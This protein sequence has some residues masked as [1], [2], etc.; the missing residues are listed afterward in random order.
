MDDTTKAKF[1]E[2]ARLKN[3]AAAIKER[4][5]LLEPELLDTMLGIDGVNTKIE[6]P[7]GAF[8]IRKTKTWTLP[9]GLV[10]AQESL[11]I[12]IATAKKEGDATFEE[13]PGLS[14]R[15]K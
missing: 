5:D 1:A 9:E 4:L 11:K 12:A 15:R 10:N 3:E 8:S 2:Y 14:F 13:V 6:T 7:I